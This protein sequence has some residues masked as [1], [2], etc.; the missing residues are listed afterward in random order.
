MVAIE[1]SVV[2]DDVAESDA[3]T[4]CD[5]LSS[6]LTAGSRLDRQSAFNRVDGALELDQGSIAHKLED[7]A[8][9]RRYGRV[10]Y[11]RT[12]SFQRREGT[13]LVA[14]HHSRITDHVG[15]EDREK[16]APGVRLNHQR[17]L[18]SRRLFCHPGGFLSLR[19]RRKGLVASTRCRMGR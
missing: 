9:V 13:S 17:L 11:D 4:E 2:D 14:R 1:V 7:P 16:L 3:D 10:N 6:L 12:V 5:I 19:V 15:G 18:S 8:M